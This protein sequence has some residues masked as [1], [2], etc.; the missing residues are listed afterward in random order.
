MQSERVFRETLC[1]HSSQGIKHLQARLLDKAMKKEV[2]FL[3]WGEGG[4]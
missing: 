4:G 1:K 3:F 2:F